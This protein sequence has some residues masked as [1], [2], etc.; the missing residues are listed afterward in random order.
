[1]DALRVFEVQ[2]D[3][4]NH[5]YLD[6]WAARLELTDLWKRLKQEAEPA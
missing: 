1:V 6:D 2:K 5:S 4:L 3:V